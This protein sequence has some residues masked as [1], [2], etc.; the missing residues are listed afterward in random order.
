[1]NL[2]SLPTVSTLSDSISIVEKDQIKIVRIIHD[3]ATA[4]V[5]LFGGHVLSFQPKN[6]PDLL[7]MSDISAFDG[8]TAIRGGIPVCWPWFSNISSPNHGFARI[9]EWKIVEHRENE[10]GVMLCLGLDANRHTLPQWPHQFKLRLYVEVGDELK[11]TLDIKNN[12][13]QAWAF[14]SALHSYLNIGD[15]NKVSVTG[16]GASYIDKLQSGAVCKGGDTLTLTS[17]IDRIYTE[18]QSKISVQD[19]VLDRCIN[20]ENSGNNTAVLWNPWVENS[21]ASADISDDGY[22]TMLCVESVLY[23]PTLEKSK[24]LEPGESYKLATTISA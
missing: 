2:L 23:A 1:M 3:K 18:P 22:L 6:K 7:W 4:A 21:K 16:M 24:V 14:T 19:P 17:G 12:D 13:T 10:E 15:I 11:V 5:S 8:K 9:N 20:V